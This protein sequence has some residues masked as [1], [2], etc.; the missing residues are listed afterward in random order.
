MKKGFKMVAL[1]AATTMLFA[2]NGGEMAGFKTTDNGLYYKFE[3]QN[4]DGQQVQEGD[5]LVGEMTVR[6]DTM[7]LFSTKGEATRIAQAAPSFNG[8]LYE[9]L[10]M[11]HVGDIATF[12]IEA[13]SL[14]KYVQPN[15]MPQGY[16]P[17]KGMK[18]FYEINLQDIVTKEDLAAEQANF[19]EERHG[20]KG[21]H[22]QRSLCE[23]HR[24][25]ARR[26]DVRH[27]RRGRCP[28]RRDLQQGP[29][30]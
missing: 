23:L 14:A 1:A 27:Q 4:K 30:V 25:P 24:P 26:H 13:D 15:Q 9:G 22:R 6:F 10:I 7:E 11:M 20:C 21:R 29:Q 18:I 12:A 28:Q 16:E 19:E 17:G 5:V 8:G 2:C 3:K